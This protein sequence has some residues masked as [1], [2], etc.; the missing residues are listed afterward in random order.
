M[1][2]NTPEAMHT[3]LMKFRLNNTERKQIYNNLHNKFIM[4]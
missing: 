1:Y 3:D 4:I 2:V